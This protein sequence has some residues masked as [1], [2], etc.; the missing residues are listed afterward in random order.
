MQH[1]GKNMSKFKIVPKVKKNLINIYNIYH[2]VGNSDN[3]KAN[4]PRSENWYFLPSVLS[5]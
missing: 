4:S 5:R 1:G 2:A 3:R